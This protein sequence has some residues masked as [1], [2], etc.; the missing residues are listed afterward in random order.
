[1]PFFDSILI[2][3]PYPVLSAL[4]WIIAALLATAGGLALL[5]VT[6]LIKEIN[7][8]A[9]MTCGCHAVESADPA[10]SN[11]PDRTCCRVPA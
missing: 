5:D 4:L 10:R 9:L 6:S 8:T 7:E 1:M 3:T 11:L 2:L